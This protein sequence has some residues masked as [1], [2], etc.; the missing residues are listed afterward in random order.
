MEEIYRL[1]VAALSQTLSLSQELL[2][3][4][5]TYIIGT[6]PTLLLPQVLHMIFKLE[7]AVTLF[8]KNG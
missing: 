5:P 1:A 6:I 4:Q 8:Q 7:N 2:D 3:A